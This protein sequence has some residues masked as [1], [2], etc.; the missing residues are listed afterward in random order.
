MPPH[1][2]IAHVDMDAFYASVEQRDNPDYR[3]KPV[4]VGADPK[5]GRGR[6][7][8]AACSYEARKYGIHSA[9]PISTAFRKCPHAIFLRGD[10]KKYGDVSRQIFKV[11]E[12]FSPDIE[13]ISI[14]E[15][16]IDITGSYHL[17]GTPRETCL[18]IKKAILLATGLKASIGLAPNK[19]TAK[20]ASDLEK[21]DGVVI[22]GE[23][24]LLEFLHPLP[25]GKLWG[26]G[27][28]SR[29][30]LNRLGIKTIGD[31]A[32]RDVQELI[33]L[34]GKNGMHIWK[35]ANGIDSREVKPEDSIKSIGNE[36]TFDKDEIDT[37]KI[38]DTLMRL[39]EKISRRLRKAG[40]KGKTITLKIRFADFKTYTRATTLK[41]PTNFV[42]DIY[43]NA[44][45]KVQAFQLKQNPV[46]LIGI[47]VSQLRQ[48]LSQGLLFEK[49]LPESKKEEKLHSAL[50][51]IKE[52][53][54]EHSIKHRK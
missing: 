47:Q 50:D 6:G 38:K 30:A 14:D 42:K 51:K 27:K 44:W 33:R 25:A 37:D 43:Q 26:V 16:F 20:I 17:F 21:P 15:A 10:M 1:R 52:K 22:V 4:I 8:V 41:E 7:V 49:S 28:K 29:E 34:F 23:E 48:E 24:N 35:L 12:S 9:M 19:M 36:Y 5:A 11:L 2:F 46:R 18:K 39:S 3:G 32:K 54:G 53:F 13:P 45:V 40:F 31:I